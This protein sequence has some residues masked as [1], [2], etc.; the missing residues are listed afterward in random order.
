MGW[1]P[2]L[3]TGMIVQNKKGGMCC[4]HFREMEDD[5]NE[6]YGDRARSAK[7]Y[8]RYWEWTRR[9]VRLG[10]S[11][12]TRSGGAVIFHLTPCLIGMKLFQRHWLGEKSR[13]D[14]IDTGRTL[15]A[16]Q[17]AQALREDESDRCR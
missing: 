1:S 10:G 8:S 6:G 9:H 14:G 4:I 12:K 5:H 16:P 17:F 2:R 13:R 15:M 11:A 7:E 3:I